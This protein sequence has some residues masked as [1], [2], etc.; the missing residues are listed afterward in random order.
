MLAR[1]R[2]LTD[3]AQHVL[4]LLAVFGRPVGP[5][6]LVAAAGRSGDAVALA[7]RA[8]AVHILEPD[9]GGTQLAFRHAL[10]REALYAELLPGERE[11]LHDA[12]LTAL[13]ASGAGAAELAH[14]QLAAGRRAEALGSSIDAGLEDVRRAA[15]PEALT[16]FERALELWDEV[17]RSGPEPARW[18]AST[19]AGRRPRRP[20][21]R[22][23]TTARSSTAASRWSSSTS[24]AN[25]CAQPGSSSA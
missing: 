20:A 4:R 8:V 22:A 9:A 23:S 2:A 15:Y 6:L 17:R 10:V 24:P 12:V 19:S 13:E 21:S 11:A 25:P 7:R 5:E 16:H 14:H 1:V 3:D 18:I